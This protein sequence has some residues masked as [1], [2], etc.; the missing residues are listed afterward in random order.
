M[1][2]ENISHSSIGFIT[3]VWNVFLDAA[4]RVPGKWE[5]TKRKEKKFLKFGTLVLAYESWK[6]Y[7]LMDTFTGTGLAPPFPWLRLCLAMHRGLWPSS[8]GKIFLLVLPGFESQCARLSSPQCFT[9]L[10]GLHGVQWIWGLVVVRVNWPGRTGYKKKKKR[11]CL[12][13]LCKYVFQM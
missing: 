3:R 1:T 12:A 9:C 4:A 7:S 2:N 5:N 6:S 10:L 13:T 11:L 8:R